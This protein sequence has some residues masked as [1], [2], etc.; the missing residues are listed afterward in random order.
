M[1]ALASEVNMWF[2][3]GMERKINVGDVVYLASGGPPMTI[4]KINKPCSDYPDGL[5]AVSWFSN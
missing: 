2:D 4:I 5:I 1:L 3:G